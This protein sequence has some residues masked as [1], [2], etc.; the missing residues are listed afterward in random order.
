MTAET[1]GIS[2]DGARITIS[3][4][5]PLSSLMV[6]DRVPGIAPPARRSR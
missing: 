6:A 4:A 1:F 3:F 5:D 2:P